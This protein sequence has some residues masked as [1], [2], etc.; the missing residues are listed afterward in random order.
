MSIKTDNTPCLTTH[1]EFEWQGR[2][3]LEDAEL[4]TRV[5]HIIESQQAVNLAEHADAVSILGFATDAGVARNKGR[6]GAGKGPDQIR[7]ALAN[8]AWHENSTLVDLGNVYCQGDQLE[9][10]QVECARVITTALQHTPVI[11]LGGGHEIAWA[12]FKGLADHFHYLK[13]NTPKI[14]IINFDA[15][16]DLRK[17]QHDNEEIKPSSGTPFSQIQSYCE[18]QNWGFNYACL[19]VSRSSNTPA[20]FQ[21]ADSLN[22]W[23]VEDK[24]LTTL[25]YNEHL[26]QLEAFVASVD[27]VY[28]TIDLDVFPAATAPGVSAPAPAGVTFDVISGYLDCIFSHSDKLLIADIAEYNPTYD[29]DGQTARLAARLCWEIANAMSNR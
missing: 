23:Y 17:F 15:H 20:L 19:G 24:H 27:V 1:H 28:L 25:H 8:M 22:V 10:A 7:Q 14:G 5:H 29:I 16:F 13:S 4:G 21:Q 6:I 26:A 3:D 2:T 12:S 11:T 9:S 18:Q